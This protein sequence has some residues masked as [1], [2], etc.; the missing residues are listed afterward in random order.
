[1][2]IAFTYNLKTSNS[3]KEGEFDT[4]ETFHSLVNNFES[5]GHKVYSIDVNEWACFSYLSSS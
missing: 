3:E 4:L 1:M 5:L 2:K